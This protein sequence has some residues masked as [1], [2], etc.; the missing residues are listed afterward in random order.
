MNYNPEFKFLVFSDCDEYL[1]DNKFHINII[2][3][4]V[5][6]VVFVVWKVLVFKS[7]VGCRHVGSI[8]CC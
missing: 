5:L 6:F 2:C 8:V 7:D 1:N 3:H 4:F